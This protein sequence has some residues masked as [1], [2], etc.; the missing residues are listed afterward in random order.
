MFHM[1]ASVNV[2]NILVCRFPSKNV[3]ATSQELI[4]ISNKKKSK[5][6]Y[7]HVIFVS[8]KIATKWLTQ[9]GASNNQN[10]S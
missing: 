1:Y 5:C 9:D 2:P 6:K 8:W 3:S 10:I 7:I 4:Q